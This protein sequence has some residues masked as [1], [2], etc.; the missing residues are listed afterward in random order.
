MSQS[1]REWAD[2][3]LWSVRS[4]LSQLGSKGVELVLGSSGDGPSQIRRQVS[5]NVS[6]REDT[7]VPRRAYDGNVVLAGMCHLGAYMDGRY[8]TR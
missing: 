1:T 7:S 2:T 5:H 6:R 4:E 8:L 3:W